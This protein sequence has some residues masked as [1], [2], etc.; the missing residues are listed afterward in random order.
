MTIKRFDLSN[1]LR[2]IK[3]DWII[4]WALKPP[5]PW[6]VRQFGKK[7]TGWAQSFGYWQDY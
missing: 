7:L 3:S 4:L 1:M 5:G 2:D 6:P